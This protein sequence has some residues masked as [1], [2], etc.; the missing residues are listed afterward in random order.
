MTTFYF[1]RHGQMDTAMAGE[2]FYKGF[3]YNMMT[4]SGECTAR[5]FHIND[6]WVILHIKN[7]DIYVTGNNSKFLSKDVITEFRGMGL[8]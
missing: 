6:D 2:K 4:L 3:G 5:H 7:V 1:I 8:L